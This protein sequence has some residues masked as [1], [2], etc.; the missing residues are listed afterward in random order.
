MGDNVT[1]VT[2]G[3]MRFLKGQSD[4]KNGLPSPPRPADD[5]PCT[6]LESAQWLGWMFQR[7]LG[8]MKQARVKEMLGR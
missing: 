3:Y 6:S 7:G 8:L 4:F 5:D 2:P 1:K